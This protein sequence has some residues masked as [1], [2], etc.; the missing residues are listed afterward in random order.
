VDR[1]L[2]RAEEVLEIAA[3]AGENASE[4]LILFDHMG[5]MRMFDPAG[6]SVTGLICEFGAREIFRIEKRNGAV[7]VEGWSASQQCLLQRKVGRPALPAFYP[8][9]LRAVPRLAA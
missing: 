6:W 8:I 2:K 1:F 4:C 7:R 3:T 5:G 9:T